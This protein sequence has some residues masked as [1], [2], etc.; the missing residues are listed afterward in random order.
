VPVRKFRTVVDMPP[1]VEG[2][3][4]VRGIELACRLSDLATRLR[5]R[6]FP[7]GT[8]RY[9]SVES[10]AEAR[11]AWERQGPARPAAVD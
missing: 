2:P 7:A 3:R 11:E 6:R 1:A 4:G 8:H 10:A 9:R 5:P